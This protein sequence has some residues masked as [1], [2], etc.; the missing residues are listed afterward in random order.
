M[1]KHERV[2]PAQ[3]CLSLSEMEYFMYSD[4]ENSVENS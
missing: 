2:I 1:S 3:W 4:I